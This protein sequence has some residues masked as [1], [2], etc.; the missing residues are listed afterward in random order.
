MLILPASNKFEGDYEK[1]D[2]EPTFGA[3]TWSSDCYAEEDEIIEKNREIF[4]EVL[5]SLTPIFLPSSS[6]SFIV[7]RLETDNYCCLVLLC[8]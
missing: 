3:T 5:V 6:S 8:V 1:E 7:C 4:K 2:S